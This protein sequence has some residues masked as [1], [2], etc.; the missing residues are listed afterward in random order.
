MPKRYYDL[1]PKIHDFANLW[2]A[3][4]RA[5]QGKRSHPSVARFEY[6]LESELIALQTELHD[7]SYRPGGY[8][9]FTIHDPKR[10]R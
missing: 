7:G 3:F 4:D 5:S 10:R 1:Y 2:L 6:D 8:R 9:S